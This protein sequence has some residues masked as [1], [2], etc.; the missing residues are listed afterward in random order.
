MD[1]KEEIREVKETDDER[2]KRAGKFRNRYGYALLVSSVALLLSFA[3]AVVGWTKKNVLFDFDTLYP[4]YAFLAL[5]YLAY[6]AA[7]HRKRNVLD[8]I[9]AAVLVASV[10]AIT[11]QCVLYF[12]RPRTGNYYFELYYEFPGVLRYCTYFLVSQ[13]KE[14]Y[15]LNSTVYLFDPTL[16]ASLICLAVSLVLY[17]MERKKGGKI[18]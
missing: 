4:A 14:T 18:R 3:V 5:V 11:V 9:I 16:V 8:W 17:F 13:E 15:E 12:Y 1:K 6:T 7:T 2:L 10:T